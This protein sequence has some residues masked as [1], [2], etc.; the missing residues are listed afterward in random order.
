MQIIISLGGSRYEAQIGAVAILL[1]AWAAWAVWER[2]TRAG[3]CHG[4]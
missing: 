3:G 4:S 1:A 2:A